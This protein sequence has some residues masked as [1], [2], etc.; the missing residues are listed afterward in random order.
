[1]FLDQSNIP[2]RILKNAF[3]VNGQ[4]KKFVVQLNVNGDPNK[5]HFYVRQM[6]LMK[7][8][9]L[10]VKSAWQKRSIFYNEKRR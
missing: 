2:D 1:M 7:M 8:T 6:K 3:Q 9:I 4:P 10:F 5:K